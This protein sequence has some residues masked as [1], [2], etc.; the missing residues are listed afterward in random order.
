MKL[1]KL[2]K[3]KP[4]CNDLHL[5]LIPIL[6][7]LVGFKYYLFFIALALYLIYIF[8]KTKL[9][10]PILSLILVFSLDIFLIKMKEKI[11]IKDNIDAYIKEINDENNYIILYKGILIKV[12]EYNHQ[13]NP[14]DIINLDIKIE[15]IE[16]KSYQNDFDYKEYLKTEG[17]TYL[18]KGK[19]LKKK[20]SFFSIST[21]KYNYL[22]YLKKHLSI[23]TYTHVTH[24]GK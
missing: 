11:E 14:G 13:N 5:I 7:F 4:F 1:L 15:E 18:A 22:K 6:L 12:N 16:E 23:D 17:I 2:L 8:L 24:L 19:T 9:I 10:I 20:N 3:K 21:L